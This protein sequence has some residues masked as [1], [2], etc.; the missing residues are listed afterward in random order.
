MS[1]KLESHHA[2]Y[3]LSRDAYKVGSWSFL[4]KGSLASNFSWLLSSQPDMRASMPS[5]IGIRSK[6]GDNGPNPNTCSKSSG[7]GPG[8]WRSLQ[9]G[10]HYYTNFI[11]SKVQ[12]CAMKWAKLSS[13]GHLKVFQM[14]ELLRIKSR[15]FLANKN[16]TN[17]MKKT[18]YQR[19][20]HEKTQKRNRNS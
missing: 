11:G 9:S 14:Q 19:S 2:K 20:N 3:A 10:Y 4:T 15:N 7:S 13:R 12:K 16:F 8:R 5:I 18:K 6:P 17:F 1:T